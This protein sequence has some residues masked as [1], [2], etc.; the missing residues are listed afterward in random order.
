MYRIFFVGRLVPAG[1]ARPVAPEVMEVYRALQPT[2]E[3]RRGVAEFPKEIRRSGEWLRRLA[4][5]AP[6]ELGDRPMLL[7]W[8]H[9]DRAFGRQRSVR[10]RWMRD[11]PSAEDVDL[12]EASHYI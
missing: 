4:E 6:R 3:A 2:P 5:R 10:D 8:G 7:F 12:P 1:V 9:R 11:F